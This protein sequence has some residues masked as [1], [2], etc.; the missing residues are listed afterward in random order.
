MFQEA[1]FNGFIKKE[2]RNN[3]V[4]VFRPEFIFYYLDS[5]NEHH[6]LSENSAISQQEQHSSI[7]KVFY[8]APGTGKSHKVNEIIK[9]KEGRTERVTFHPEY[10]YSS[11]VGGYKPAMDGDN[12]KYEFVPKLSQ[13]FYKRR[14]DLD[15]DY[16]LVIEEINRGNCAEI[17]GDIPAIR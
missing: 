9:G 5:I 11:F 2:Y 14:N 6:I 15:N 10:D 3:T 17:F 16:Y 12:I 7:N 4:C 13:I 1:R 8:G